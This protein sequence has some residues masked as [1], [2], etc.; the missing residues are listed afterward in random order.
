MINT[1]RG[2]GQGRTQAEQ[3]AADLELQFDAWGPRPAPSI[4]PVPP[5]VPV[6]GAPWNPV[7]VLDHRTR[8]R[9]DNSL[10]PPVRLVRKDP[11][12]DGTYLAAGR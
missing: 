4:R 6:D 9:A 8:V 1:A 5:A 11:H 3:T 10:V 12:G 2:T 7:G